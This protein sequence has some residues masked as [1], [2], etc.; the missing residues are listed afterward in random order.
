VSA[1]D[2]ASRASGGNLAATAPGSV[3]VHL[4]G[5][6]D[7]PTSLELFR[8]NGDDLLDRWDGT[9]LLRTLRVGNATSA[10]VCT[11][12]GSLAEPV[13]QITVDDPAHLP[14]VEQA[15]ADTFFPAPPAFA[16]LLERDPVIARLDAAYPGLRTVRQFDLLAALIRCISAQQVNLRWAVTT[17]RRLAETFGERHH[18]G[19]QIVYSLSAERLAAASVEEIRALQFTTRKAEYIIHVAEAIASGHLAVDE[20][21]ALP[22]EEVI[23]RLVTLRGIGRWTAEWILARTLGRPAVVA[24]DLGVRKAVG[25]AYLGTSLPPEPAVRQATA[26]W[27]PSAGVAQT[28]LLHGLALDR[29][30]I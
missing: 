21:E 24:G 3:T 26:H 23:A 1:F 28:L 11:V 27:G 25:L 22:D 20:L 2:A 5:P 10:Y 7:I 4:P 16:D 30:T 6:L 13:L 8:S 12:A 17:R 15:A 14:E 18:V 29:L 9:H 19:E